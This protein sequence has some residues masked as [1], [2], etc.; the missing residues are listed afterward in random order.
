M[1]WV[2][3]EG[4]AER[5]WEEA[6]RDLWDREESCCRLRLIEWAVAERE[7]GSESR[8]EEREREERRER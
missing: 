5:W 1:S 6:T 4:T 3:E 2:V 7:E 8:T